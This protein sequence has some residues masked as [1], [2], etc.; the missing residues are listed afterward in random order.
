MRKTIL[1]FLLFFGVTT[2]VQAGQIIELG[3]LP[4]KAQQF[5]KQHF[6]KAKVLY[7]KYD[8][9]I[10]EKSYEVAMEGANVEFDGKGEW[11][12]VECKKGAVPDA[13]VPQQI[14]SYVSSKYEGTKIKEIDRDKWGYEVKISNGLEIK[15]DKNFKVKNIE[16]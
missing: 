5:I 4:Q 6:P 1:A 15:F 12:N 10:I 13:I 8:N 14:R 9:E 2:A 11:D 7:V 16:N 3:K